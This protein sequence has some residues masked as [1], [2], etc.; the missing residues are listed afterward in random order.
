MAYRTTQV[1][2]II[3]DDATLD[4]VDYDRQS[5]VYQTKDLQVFHTVK[6]VA[7]ADAETQVSIAPVTTGYF[8]DIRSDYPV[9]VRING[10]S[11]TQFTLKSNGVSPT[12]L[13]APLPDQCVFVG[14]MTV[15]RIDIAPISGATQTANVKIAVSG[16]PQSS[17]I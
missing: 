4:Q 17:Y 16:D 5:T 1:R 7:P 13:G 15:T 14:T 3:A 9:L 11:A 8:L 2:T 6:R 12:N 10:V